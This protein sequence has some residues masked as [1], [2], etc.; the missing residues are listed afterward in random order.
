MLVDPRTSLIDQAQSNEEWDIIVVGGGASGLSCAWDAASRGLKVALIEQG[1]FT[2]A[3]SSRSTKLLHGG[4]RY[5]QN[6]EVSLVREALLERSLMLKNAPEFCHAQRFIL[7]T[8]QSLA[9]YYYRIG[10]WVYDALAGKSNIKKAEL[11]SARQLHSQLPRYHKAHSTGGVAYTDAQFDDSALAIALAQCVNL[12]G[13]LAINYVCCDSLILKN[14]KVRGVHVSDAETGKSWSMHAKA[15][16]NATGVFSDV[17]RQHTNSSSKWSIRTSRGTHIV[18]PNN[19]LGSNNALIVPKT[20][21]GRVLFAIPWKHHTIIGT[22]DVPTD[23]PEL[24]PQPSPQEVSFLLKEAQEYFPLKEKHISS[25]WAG[26]RPL[27]SRANKGSTASLSRK[28]IIDLSNNGLVSI[29]GGKWTTARK[30]AEDTID[31]VILTHGLKNTPS[32]T[33]QLRLTEHG[34][35]RPLLESPIPNTTIPASH[36]EDYFAHYYARNAEDILTRRNR[37]TMLNQSA[38]Q[39]SK[40]EVTSLLDSLV[41]PANKA[42]V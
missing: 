4:V 38:S 19:P 17:F 24:D 7:P 40:A 11:L 12:N 25:S 42:C 34:A 10:M 16:V 14:G 32:R 8:H 20:T 3:T 21:D 23:K 28:H 6:G 31:A 37:L 30:M 35:R 39:S 36:I 26:L 1:D 9:R 18:V 41:K 13:N 22:T 27:V 5:L 29:L 33:S 15:V 2:T